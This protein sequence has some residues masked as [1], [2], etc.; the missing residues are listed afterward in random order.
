MTT[1]SP[2][3]MPIRYNGVMNTPLVFPIVKRMLEMDEVKASDFTDIADIHTVETR[4]PLLIE[5][6]IIVSEI[7]DTGRRCYLYRLTDRGRMFAQSMVIAD[8]ISRD[9]MDMDYQELSESIDEIYSHTR[10]RTIRS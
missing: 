8:S 3:L 2:F 10:H 5:Q 4:F 6:G 9:I 1:L 7:R